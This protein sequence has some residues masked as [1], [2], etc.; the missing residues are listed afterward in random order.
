VDGRK[1]SQERLKAV[2]FGSERSNTTIRLRLNM[3]LNT[4]RAGGATVTLLQDEI[5]V[6]I[7]YTGGTPITPVFPQCPENPTRVRARAIPY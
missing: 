2:A 4:L 5:N 1:N 3:E 7:T 6:T